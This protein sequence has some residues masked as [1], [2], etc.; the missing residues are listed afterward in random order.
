[1]RLPMQLPWAIRAPSIPEK[2][3]NEHR[4]KR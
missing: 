4:C 2:L 3:E 1:M